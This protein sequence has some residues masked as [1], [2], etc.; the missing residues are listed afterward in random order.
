MRTATLLRLPCLVG[1]CMSFDSSSLIWILVA[2]MTLQPLL[3]VFGE[4]STTGALV[5]K[6]LYV[7][8]ES[9]AQA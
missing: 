8:V 1:V 3:N 4:P 9:V 6:L 2:A 7:N 5:L